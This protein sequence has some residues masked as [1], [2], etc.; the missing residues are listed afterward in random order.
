MGRRAIL[1][2]GSDFSSGSTER[3]EKYP[4]I[5]F[6]EKRTM[7]LS[8]ALARF[9]FECSGIVNATSHRMNE[10]IRQAFHD[11]GPEDFLV[12]HVLGHSRSGPHGGLS[13]MGSDGDTREYASANE[14]IS[15]LSGMTEGPQTLFILDICNGGTAI[16]MTEYANL[17]RPAPNERTWII[18]GTDSREMAFNGNFTQAITR[19]L[20]SISDGDSNLSPDLAYAPFSYIT[21]ETQRELTSASQETF[22]QTVVIGPG[23]TLDASEF[24]FFPNPDHTAPPTTSHGDRVWCVSS[25][26]ETRGTPRIAV[27]GDE[28]LRVFDPRT[29][30]LTA[31]TRADGVFAVVPVPLQDL[32]VCAGRSGAV[33][34]RSAVDLGLRREL[35]SHS[36][37]VNDLDCV[38]G[39]GHWAVWSVS[40]DGSLWSGD[41]DGGTRVH[42]PRAHDGFANAVVAIGSFVVSAGSH[43]DVAAW[44]STTGDLKWRVSEHSG[45]VHRLAALGVEGSVAI[46]SGGDDGAL[47][48]WDLSDGTLLRTLPARST[49]IRAMTVLSAPGHCVA[50][51]G[52]TEPVSVWD[53]ATGEKVAALADGSDIWSL[54]VDEVGGEIRLFTGG[55]EGLVP[56]SLP[57]SV[58]TVRGRT[59]SPGPADHPPRR[60]HRR[61]SRGHR[62]AGHSPTG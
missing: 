32:L 37:Q 3:S 35:W 48:I 47:R 1:I 58:S 31:N 52:P 9:D 13:I 14:W 26:V 53:V 43:G 61:R 6:A 27:G 11:G 34:V 5:P 41:I 16:P 17:P 2:A 10:E 55:D 30:A 23:D 60:L 8:G 29:R 46:V 50:V 24:R 51:G 49:P 21:R 44:D 15:T 42:I 45:P 39:D 28:S 38:V 18:A 40:D 36:A 57:D 22:P 7:D 19:V 33:E 59:S 4:P 12:V 20:A 54:A 56:L 62:P 25:L